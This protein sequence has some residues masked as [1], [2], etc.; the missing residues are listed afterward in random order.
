MSSKPVRSK[1]KSQTGE[2]EKKVRSQESKSQTETETDKMLKTEAETVPSQSAASDDTEVQVNPSFKALPGAAKAK[3]RVSSKKSR[4]SSLGKQS[5]A[6]SVAA[7]TAA[8]KIEAAA[9]EKKARI[10]QQ[11]LELQQQAK[12]LDLATQM[13]KLRVEQEALE[14]E[15]E[16]EDEGKA[17]GRV[18][19]WIDTQLEVPPTE[20]H[21]PE[22]EETH[23]PEELQLERERP[24]SVEEG[25]QSAPAREPQSEAFQSKQHQ[26]NPTAREFKPREVTVAAPTTP[27]NMAMEEMIRTLQMPKTE[28]ITFDGDPTRFW[29]FMRAFENNVGKY[30]V[31]EHAKLARLL[32]YCRGKAHKLVETCTA[33]EYGGY[34]RAKDL[35]RKRFGDKYAI[36][37]AWLNR[38]TSG[39]KIHNETLQDLADEMLRCRE[40]LNAIGCYGEVNQRVLVQIAERLP[41]YLQHRW[42]HQVSKAREATGQHASFDDLV[43]FT[44]T[45]AREVN[46]RV[47]GGLG[48]AASKAKTA[49]QPFK[50]TQNA[51]KKGFH[52]AT[53]GYERK[54]LACHS[55]GCGSLFRCEAFK[56]MTPE[57][58]YELAK[59]NRLCFNC[60]GRGHLTA[61]CKQE[62]SCA[63]PGCRLKH[64]KFLHFEQK[65][66]PQLHQKAEATC[67]YTSTRAPKVVLPVVEVQVQSQSGHTADTY[68]LLDSGSTDT[69]CT[70]GLLEELKS[71][72]RQANLSLLTLSSEG[73]KLDT[74]AHELKVTDRQGGNEILIPHVYA[75]Q[76]IPV[77]KY[78]SSQQEDLATWDH[79]AGIEAPGLPEDGEV[80]LLIGQD[81]PEA[82]MPL[83]VRSATDHRASAPFATRTLFGW[84][85]SGPVGS[86]ATSTVTALTCTTLEQQLER[87]WKVDGY[88]NSTEKGPSVEDQR[89]QKIMERSIQKD[90]GHYTVAI[91]FRHEKSLPNNKAMAEKRLEGLGKKLDRNPALRKAYDE[92]MKSL[93]QKGHAEKVPESY[94]PVKKG[95]EWYIPHHP[96]INPNKKKNPSGVRLCGQV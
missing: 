22:G 29:T 19:E 62:K 80:G 57:K 3:S 54:C 53:S 33:M 70:K 45:A 31:D 92:S 27:I 56:K 61:D 12:K 6:A 4:A 89:A 63:A 86:V 65:D 95:A 55:D 41:T 5:S 34:Q 49:G 69:F 85:I 78:C 9:L 52:G 72:G 28:M 67:S 21:Q 40:T 60:L 24:A 71:E 20:D 36:S 42:R 50:G 47:F 26:L 1:S 44:Q 37:A 14:E 94:P 84:T 43:K 17:M 96:V 58:R 77:S 38:I 76:K 25:A 59:N 68:A 91:P 90:G 48:S 8:L 51:Q 74:A 64:T 35:L 93:F 46:D 23:L 83:E 73:K 87:F 32:Q 16:D 7:K 18:Q 30:N 13:E 11:M 88:V 15:E 81:C 10:E 66:A 79:L 82:F 2:K 75:C 39:P